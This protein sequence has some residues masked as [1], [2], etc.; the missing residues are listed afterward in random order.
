MRISTLAPPQLSQGIVELS[1]VTPAIS[2]FY[3]LQ[4]DRRKSGRRRRASA[5]RERRGLD[6]ARAATVSLVDIGPFDLAAGELLGV[7]D[8]IP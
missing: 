5:Q 2:P 3:E 1:F 7:L 6:F 8:D 4:L